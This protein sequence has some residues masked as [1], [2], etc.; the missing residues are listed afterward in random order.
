MKCLKTAALLA[1]MNVASIPATL[2]VSSLLANPAVAETCTLDCKT[3]TAVGKGQLVPIHTVRYCII[4]PADGDYQVVACQDPR[5]V[6]K[7]PAGKDV[8]CFVDERGLPGYDY[9][10]VVWEG[11]KFFAHK[12]NGVWQPHWK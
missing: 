5:A 11:R 3:P 9:Q 10:E 7:S 1:A 2:G 12:V 8:V 4:G 6:H